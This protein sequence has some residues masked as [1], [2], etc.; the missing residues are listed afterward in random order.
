MK[1]IAPDSEPAF[2][3]GD[4]QPGQ[5]LHGRKQ[6]LTNAPDILSLEVAFIPVCS[7]FFSGEVRS[8]SAL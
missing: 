2:Q 5:G 7:V 6:V 4:H 1:G 8:Q 3:V